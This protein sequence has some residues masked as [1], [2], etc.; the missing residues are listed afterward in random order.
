MSNLRS[1]F[2]HLDPKSRVLAFPSTAKHATKLLLTDTH[3]ATQITRSAGPGLAKTSQLLNRWPPPGVVAE[4]VQNHLLIKNVGRLG[5]LTRVESWLKESASS[6]NHETTLKSDDLHIHIGHQQ[7]PAALVLPRY[8]R[9]TFHDES[10][11]E[12]KT[13]KP[14][15]KYRSHYR[16][17]PTTTTTMT[18]ARPPSKAPPDTND[19]EVD[20]E[21]TFWHPAGLR[22]ARDLVKA[23]VERSWTSD[24]AQEFGERQNNSQTLP[25]LSSST[26]SIMDDLNAML[27]FREQVDLTGEAEDGASEFNFGG[28]ESSKQRERPTHFPS[29]STSN[30]QHR[31][32][33]QN[34][35][36]S[37][38]NHTNHH[39]QS[40][41]AG[42][43]SSSGRPPRQFGGNSFYNH[44]STNI[45]ATQ[46]N[47]SHPAKPSS[48]PL[49]GRSSHGLAHL[50]NP[51]QHQ[52]SCVLPS[53]DLPSI[54][55]S[56]TGSSSSNAYQTLPPIMRE[57]QGGRSG[58]ANSHNIKSFL[59]VSKAM[60]NSNNHYGTMNQSLTSTNSLS[61]K[62][63]SVAGKCLAS[64]TSLPSN[65]PESSTPSSPIHFSQ[66]TFDGSFGNDQMAQQSRAKMA[67]KKRKT[68]EEEDVNSKRQKV[69]KKRY[70]K[71][72]DT[73]T[74]SAKER[75]GQDIWMRILEF[76][77]P[78]FLKKAR[79]I[80][81]E[82]RD[83]VDKFDSIFVNCRK[84]N[85]GWDM[86][87]PPPGLTERQYSDLLGGK[88]CQEPGCTNKKA[89]RTYWS[90]A[91]RWCSDCWEKNIEREDRILKGRQNQYGR[92][93]VM[94]LLECISVAIHDSFVKPH[95]YTEEVESRSRGPPRLY[96]CYLSKDIDQ[97]IEAY[98]AL[99]PPPYKEDPNHTPAEK[100]AAQAAHKALM[101][102]LEDKRSEFFA[103]GKAKNDEHMAKVMK[104]E[105]AI[106]TKRMEERK[107][108]DQARKS[109]FELFTRRAREDL[110]HISSE[111]VQKTKC[112]K[113]S[114]RIYRDGGTERGWRALKPK[115]EKE[116]E[117][118]DLNP[119]K[120]S[121]SGSSSLRNNAADRDEN[122]IDEADDHDMGLSD[123]EL[124]NGNSEP[125]RPAAARRAHPFHDAPQAFPRSRNLL[126][127]ASGQ[128]RPSDTGLNFG[129]PSHQHS[130]QHSHD[131][132]SFAH[133][134]LPFP[135][136]SMNGQGYPTSL[137]R[138]VSNYPSFSS[139]HHHMSSIMNGMNGYP[140]QGSSSLNSS[141]THIPVNSLLRPPTPAPRRNTFQ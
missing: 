112:F 54:D 31:V 63:N 44:Q 24:A 122:G 13:Y 30:L 50:P 18:D 91:K 133:P 106:R 98:E 76:T 89:S 127:Q 115:I 46:A 108:K 8:M 20:L 19:S 123:M 99:T 128:F 130:H 51:T 23:L 27:T 126:L 1:T 84:E 58:P 104:I 35:E 117:L 11:I 26:S 37:Q 77:P 10:D 136:Q 28:S 109:R 12:C 79:L 49:L 15:V 138:P 32:S 52:V 69:D 75:I 102:A 53:L 40:A 137:P 118:S 67:S 124:D 16:P 5:F 48:L 88:G 70:T 72:K 80:S 129:Y 42:F 103:A 82:F 59:P 113:A 101:D 64:S 71:V 56:F 21:Q 6:R 94:K 95:D 86:P 135:G 78:S 9:P 93:T 61:S 90:W 45:A 81:R 25:S 121:N 140:R 132:S 38:N 7:Q 74:V 83:T 22:T 85:Y 3:L 33:S 96:K 65:T 41:I 14:D 125:Q 92:T 2:G 17:L 73:R 60:N 39:S 116:W 119:A 36:S 47:S 100:S 4:P 134:N 131:H 29:H 120:P 66:T 97:I 57:S 114:C 141:S 34:I 110:P 111:F 105:T 62:K 107:P 87:P 68:A 139:N 55:S 43:P